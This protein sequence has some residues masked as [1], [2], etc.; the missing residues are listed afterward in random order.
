[1]KTVV[2]FILIILLGVL[3][4]ALIVAAVRR[5]IQNKKS[6]QSIGQAMLGNSYGKTESK[7][8]DS[9][10]CP[11]CKSV[12]LQVMGQER[13]EFSAGK[14][15]GGALLT[16]GVG[17]LAGFAGKK[18]RYDILCNNCGKQFQV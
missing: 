11:K 13:K 1:M 16:G 9:I 3:G 10:K 2:A 7:A 4:L 18:G 6:G 5:I 15:L 14:A 8:D 17:L 12:N